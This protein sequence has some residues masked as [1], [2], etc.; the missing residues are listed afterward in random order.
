[1]EKY[2]NGELFKDVPSGLNF[3]ELKKREKRKHLLND[4]IEKCY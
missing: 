1:M 2:N 4:I 3:L